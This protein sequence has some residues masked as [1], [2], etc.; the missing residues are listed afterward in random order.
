M[1]RPLCSALLGIV[2]AISP[3]LSQTVKGVARERDTAVPLA[4]VVISLVDSQK[5]VV[6]A[7][8]T[9]EHG[10][11]A[12][13]APKAG[14]YLLEAKRIGVRPF[15]TPVFALAAGESRAD[16][17]VLD[18][19]VVRLSEVRASDQR[20][21]VR[22]PETDARTVAL[23]EDARAALTASVIT[24]RQNVTGTV[25]L[26][27]RELDHR[28]DEVFRYD[29]RE[30]RGSLARPFTSLSADQLARRGYVVGDER[31]FSYFAPDANVLLSDAFASA[32]CFR[33]VTKRDDG[34]PLNGL[35]FR[36]ARRRSVTD[37]EGVLWLDAATS[38]LR[39]VDF[40]Y[41]NLPQGEL[42]GRFGGAVH[43]RRLATGGWIVDEW[44]IRMPMTIARAGA[45][46]GRPMG[47]PLRA[48]GG[49]VVV[50]VR[51]EGGTVRVEGDDGAMSPSIAGVVHDSAGTPLGGV[52]LSLL[53]PSVATTSDSLGRFSFSGIRP[54]VYGLN[55]RAPTLDSLG[56]TL[57]AA[58]VRVPSREARNVQL[59]LPARSELARLMCGKVQDLTEKAVV[60]I[61]VVD[62]Q[63]SRPLR[64]TPAR[65]SWRTYTGGKVGF[66][67]TISGE[68]AQLD[69]SGSLTACDLPGDHL[70]EVQSIQDASLEW[71]DTVRTTPGEVS[72]RVRRVDVTRRQP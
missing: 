72:W 8:L 23:W 28:S 39:E 54:G 25:T 38:E 14:Q 56:V 45:R 2:G 4:G 69:S 55:L 18:R 47:D 7:V 9:G 10:T 27:T 36:P 58:N 30:W 57:P 17:L 16:T 43:F 29:R 67:E 1:M 19:V 35:H 11:F 63:T 15:R 42:D 64:N 52:Q 12:V 70:I 71:R 20:T 3:L 37:I 46:L 31:S 48:T 21:C 51:E 53:A 26:F 34:V 24:S 66:L 33:I 5:H 50:R 41:V 62:R 6:A 32:H 22:R 59:A 68:V 61:I 44:M 65:V 49:N 13:T 60:R 40:E